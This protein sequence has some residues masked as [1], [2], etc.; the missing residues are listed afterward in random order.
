M[1]QV[2]FELPWLAAHLTPALALVPDRFRTSKLNRFRITS[3]VQM[4]TFVS[5]KASL[6]RFM[7]WYAQTFQINESEITMDILRR[8]DLGERVQQ[9]AEALQTRQL[10]WSSIANVQNAIRTLSCPARRPTSLPCCTQYLAALIQSV[11]FALSG[12][13]DPP[14]DNHDQIA[15]LRC[16]VLPR[17]SQ[18]PDTDAPSFRAVAKPRNSPAKTSCTNAKTPTGDARDTA[19]LTSSRSQSPSVRQVGLVRSPADARQHLRQVR[20]GQPSCAAWNAS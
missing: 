2:S 1:R 19:S 12:M 4:S 9:Y 8:P 20:A 3:A 15:N 18:P 11:L 13:E 6:L 14:S 16:V 7:A 17:P 10:R 5:E